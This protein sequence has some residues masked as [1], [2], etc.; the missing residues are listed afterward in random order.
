MDNS[1]PSI[2]KKLI[3]A[4]DVSDMSHALELVAR[5]RDEVGVFKVG[6]QLFT[7]CG[8]DIVRRIRALDGEVFLDLKLHDIPNTVRHAVTEAVQLG[9]S[10]LTLH[11]TGGAA[12]LRAAAEVR[13]D[14]AG[15]AGPDLQLLGVTVLTS[16]RQE[17]LAAIGIHRSIEES[18][19]SRA[20]LAQEC[21]LQGVVASPKEISLLRSGGL[22]DLLIVTPG[23][24]SSGDSS[25]DQ[26][27]IATPAGA[28]SDGADYLVVGR[29][30]TQ[31]TDPVASV[32]RICEE[33]L[34][35]KIG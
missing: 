19:L 32:R 1:T 3:V 16:L 10:M 21:G 33:M 14:T 29:P 2:R 6:L 35:G 22:S 18:V 31:A 4:L 13:E 5:L 30:I 15:S 7:A 9:V 8:P 17:D 20:Q 34:R 12:M 23:I 24:R 25:D 27:R 11:T 28:I 26:A